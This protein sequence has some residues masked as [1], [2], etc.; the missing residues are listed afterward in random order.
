[1][2]IRSFGIE[3]HNKGL[4]QWSLRMF[5]NGPKQTKDHLGGSPCFILENDSIMVT[6]PHVAHASSKENNEHHKTT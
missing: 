2:G 5:D 1:M 3:R 4:T 6:L